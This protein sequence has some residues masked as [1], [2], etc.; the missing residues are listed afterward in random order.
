MLAKKVEYEQHVHNLSY[1]NGKPACS[2]EL[3]S[4]PSNFKVSEELSFEPTGKGEHAYLYIQKAGLN[5][6]EVA[7]ALA[8]F[9]SVP[10]KS[11]AYAGLKDKHALTKQWFSVHLAGQEGPDWDG[12]SVDD[13]RVIRSTR[14]ERKL[15]TGA[16]K[17][18]QF[19]IILTNVLGDKNDLSSRVLKISEQG[20]PNYFMQQ[21]FG[22]EANNLFLA[23]RV[24]SN[25]EPIRSRRTKSLLL[26]ATR[27]FL[28]NLVLSQRVK[29]KC[30]DKA[31]EGDVFILNSTRNYFE[32]DELTQDI[33]KRLEDGD[34]HPSGP[35]FGEGSAVVRE[36]A[37][38]REEAIFSAHLNFCHGLKNQ[39]VD[40]ARRALRIIPNKFVS[41][42]IDEET[43]QLSF[44]LHSGS[45]A[46]AVIRELINTEIRN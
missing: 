17:S 14:H 46:T 35:L 36:Q 40:F 38:M 2:G 45:Y 44:E 34:I 9:S 25:N 3:K 12:F 5:T 10:R 15:K 6:D 24:F 39:R 13:V 19:A 26:S 42:W 11:V 18:N 21:R 8:K 7:Q 28:F 37:L 31:V 29:D 30:W 20:A 1:A 33:L 41:T 16:L 23:D 22:F 27:S 32:C 4:A 43:L